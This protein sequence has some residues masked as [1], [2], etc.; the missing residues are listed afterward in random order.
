MQ[1]LS[2][3]RFRVE[4]WVK[5]LIQNLTLKEQRALFTTKRKYECER[6]IYYM[7]ARDKQK[8]RAEE[9]RSDVMLE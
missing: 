1:L 9:T 7:Q 2:E 8:K 6:V 5:T 4:R 3:P